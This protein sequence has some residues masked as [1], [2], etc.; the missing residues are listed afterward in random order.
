MASG[1]CSSRKEAKQA[2]KSGGLYINNKKVR[3][4]T[5]PLGAEHALHGKFTVVR[6]GKRHY[7]LLQWE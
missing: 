2:A 1:V 3:E 6:R 4:G 5:A 7:S